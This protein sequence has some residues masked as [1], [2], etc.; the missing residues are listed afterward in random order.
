MPYPK[1][2]GQP[3]WEKIQAEK[4]IN[5]VAQVSPEKIPMFLAVHSPIENILDKKENSYKTEDIVFHEIYSTQREIRGV[6][7]GAS[8]A[9]KSHLIRWINLRTEYEA[10]NN[11]LGLDKFKIIMVQRDTGSLK[12]ALNQIVDQLGL[13]FSKYIGAISNSLS[14]ISTKELVYELSLEI[15]ERWVDQRGREKLPAMLRR[16]GDALVSPDYMDWLCRD[17]GVIARIIARWTNSSTPEDREKKIVF[18]RD[19]VVPLT[20]INPDRTSIEVQKF[21]DDL[22]VEP[23]FKDEVVDILNT[24]LVDAQREL[25]G[26]KSDDLNS[27]FTNIRR[28]LF[29]QGK[30]LVIFIE[31]TVAASGGLDRDL[32]KA[33]EPKSGKDLCR[34]IA[35]LGMTYEGWDVL[36]DSEK[37][38]TDFVFDVGENANQWASDKEEVAKFASRYLNAIRYEE[39]EIKDL[40]INRFT[41][42]I[43]TSKCTECPFKEE[44]FPAFGYVELETGIKIGLFPFSIIAPQ[45]ILQ[46]IDI[47]RHRSSPR[48]LLEYIMDR[49]LIKAYD[50]FA[51]FAF[52]GD[53]YFNNVMRP[54]LNYWSEFKAKYLGGN[55]WVNEKNLS[56]IH[57]I[58]QFWI[59]ADS[60]DQ[61]GLLLKPYLKPLGFPPF[62][63]EIKGEGIG[64]GNG[65]DTGTDT[66]IGDGKRKA[67]SKG[68]GTGTGTDTGTVKG[69]EED[70]K[71]LEYLT[72]LDEW[73]RG[74]VLKLDTIFRQLLAGLIS[75][76]MKWQD[77]RNIPISYA[78]TMTSGTTE[79]YKH[80]RFTDQDSTVASQLYFIDIPR[81]NEV[82]NVMEALIR[83]EREG[84]KSWNFNNGEMHKRR[85]SRWLRKNKQSI[86]DSLQPKPPTLCKDAVIITTQ[87]LALTAIL[88]T[89]L[90]IFD[91]SPQERITI[92]FDKVW[93]DKNRPVVLSDRLKRLVLDAEG[94]VNGAKKFLINELGAGQGDSDPTNY[95]DPLPILKVLDS[96][97]EIILKLPPEEINKSYWQTR[98]KDVFKDTVNISRLYKDLPDIINEEYKIVENYKKDIQGFL[99]SCGYKGQ[100]L[101]TE[102]N[103][104]VIELIEIIKIQKLN[105]E[106]PNIEFD[107]L[108]N[109]S[110]LIDNLCDWCTN[111]SHADK[112]NDKSKNIEVLCFNPTPLKEIWNDLVNTTK[113]HLEKIEHDLD[114]IENR[115]TQSGGSKEELLKE[116]RQIVN[117]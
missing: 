48:G 62:S 103:S 72:V 71:L 63:E 49:A 94:K 112:I 108:W 12:S 100:N 46:H 27:I 83:F 61:A 78:K 38:R 54:A 98:F 66:R 51:Q 33:F 59:D 4:F 110:R 109:S 97:N 52:P 114:L 113:K 20:S 64:V 31:D 82:R 22:E 9:G 7:L 65:T 15:K 44:C 45:K 11:Y 88:R 28:E 115:N 13:E 57:F 106:Y 53:S 40:S 76:G 117:L 102:L 39:S 74:G 3:C 85:V 84:K 81:D 1:K 30:Q 58:A 55:A 68:T 6:V 69:T 14:R 21:L 37:D 2:F 29:V 47:E 16:L 10:N 111:I 5:I 101:G 41:S 96:F 92:L 8:G 77:F 70:K 24:V 86:V 80:I 93:D 79:Q 56:R 104:C 87:L 99:I 17:E 75:K 105:F 89:R 116:L 43:A 73:I 95:I 60:A 35:L 25:T 23:G 42:D 32:F 34:M 18:D 36:P 91:K 67:V 19:E 107:N 50:T 26:I 90:P